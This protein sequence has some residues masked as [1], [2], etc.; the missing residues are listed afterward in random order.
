M[1]E[2]QSNIF[3]IDTQIRN[4]KDRSKKIVY[5]PKCEINYTVQYYLTAA[6]S[7]N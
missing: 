3:K 1:Q 7:E 6:A 2:N 5:T 4:S